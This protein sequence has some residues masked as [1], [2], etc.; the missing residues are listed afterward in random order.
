M[1]PSKIK[2]KILAERV[3]YG[4]LGSK[5]LVI[6]TVNFCLLIC[7]LYFLYLQLVQFVHYAQR[8]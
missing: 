5:G 4:T 8:S 7:Y 6:V 2:I 1:I 3:L